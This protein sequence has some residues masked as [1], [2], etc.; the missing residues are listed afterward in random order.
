VLNRGSDRI[1]TYP[2][3]HTPT[4]YVENFGCYGSKKTENMANLTHKL[5]P[6][7]TQKLFFREIIIGGHLL[8][9][10]EINCQQLQ[11]LNYF[12]FT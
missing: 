12:L 10:L 11:A 9:I 1:D 4:S 5:D 2:M 3:I 6:A 8:V 7:I